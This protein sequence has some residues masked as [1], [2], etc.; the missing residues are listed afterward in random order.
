MLPEI[1]GRMDR[2]THMGKVVGEGMCMY[3]CWGAGYMC[4]RYVC[5]H[6]Y[7]VPVSTSDVFPR[8]QSTNIFLGRE[9]LKLIG[10]TGL[11]PWNIRNAPVSLP[12]PALSSLE[13]KNVLKL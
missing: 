10:L 9:L 2:N 13:L 3:V 12:P 5:K 1:D 6:T 7:G 11:W 4:V 8:S